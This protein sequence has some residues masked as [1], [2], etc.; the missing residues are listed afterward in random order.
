MTWN[1]ICESLVEEL[2]TE[3]WICGFLMST[4]LHNAGRLVGT[5]SAHDLAL[6]HPQAL[7]FS[8]AGHCSLLATFFSYA[9]AI[10]SDGRSVFD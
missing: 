6:Q 3:G 8:E 5:L 7:P 9:I 2:H 10:V 4:Y 1:E